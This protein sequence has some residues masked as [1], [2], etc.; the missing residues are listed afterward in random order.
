L[1]AICFISAVKYLSDYLIDIKYIAEIVGFGAEKIRSLEL[2]FAEK[3]NFD[4]YVSK[5]NYESRPEY[6]VFKEAV[7]DEL[8]QQKRVE[9]HRQLLFRKQQL[10]LK[11]KLEA[12]QFS[13][14]EKIQDKDKKLNP[15]SPLGIVSLF[16]S[17]RN[18]PLESFRINLW[19]QAMRRI[20]VL[21]GDSPIDRT[22]I[23]NRI[24]TAIVDNIN[25]TA[26]MRPQKPFDFGGIYEV[27]ASAL[28]RFEPAILAGVIQQVTARAPGIEPDA[29]LKNVVDQQGKKLTLAALPS[30][31]SPEQ[32]PNGIVPEKGW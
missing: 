28:Y 24:V 32:K 19:R 18:H 4:Y 25:Q 17:R 10:Q 8:Q 20:A 13:V 7:L 1:L 22:A 30:V 6:K 31:V 2:V 29:L 12:F 27:L 9:E 21:M 26:E 23:Q 16:L 15:T 11:E 3:F 14:N 5:E